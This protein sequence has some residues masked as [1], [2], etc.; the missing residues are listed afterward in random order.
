MNTLDKDFPTRLINSSAEKRPSLPLA[1]KNSSKPEKAVK[2]KRNQNNTHSLAANA[3][4]FQLTLNQCNNIQK[5][6]ARLSK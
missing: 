2:A 5:R 4:V 1:T 6:S 3:N